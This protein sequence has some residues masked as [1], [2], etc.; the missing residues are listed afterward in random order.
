LS[1][2]DVV[3]ESSPDEVAPERFL[4]YDVPGGLQTVALVVGRLSEEALALEWREPAPD[5]CDFLEGKAG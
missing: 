4:P 3:K 1:F 2:S 5:L